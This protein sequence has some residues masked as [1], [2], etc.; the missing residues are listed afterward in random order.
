MRKT[1]LLLAL[2]LPLLLVACGTPPELKQ[3]SLAQIEYFDAAIEAI[4]LQSEALIMA[5]ERLKK[6]AEGRIAAIEQED[7]KRWENFAVETIPTL[8]KEKLR[9]TTEEM[10]KKASQTS[11]EAERA[12]AKLSSSLEAIKAK[13]QELQAYIVKMKEVHLALD[14]Y[15]QSEKAGE[16]VTQGLLKQ[17][18]VDSLLG[19]VNE[20][21]PKVTGTINDMKTLLTGLDKGG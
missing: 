8:T 16:R 17:P 21:L 18:T 9:S 7:I 3:L 13:T 5:A 11:L 1:F 4:K 14:A 12:R 19:T 2:G 15:L 10:L 20:L 6:Q